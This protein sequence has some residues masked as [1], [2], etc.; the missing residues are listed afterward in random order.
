M[1]VRIWWLLIS[2][3]LLLLCTIAGCSA[4]PRIQAGAERVEITPPVP[5]PYNLGVEEIAHEIA[6]PL[7]ARI[8]YLEDDDDRVL[9]IAIDW[10][11]LLRTAHD[12]IR[13]AVA[14]STGLPMERIVV[15]ASHTHNAMWNNLDTEALLAEWGYHLVDREY[16]QGQLT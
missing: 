8:V 4:P 1:L 11:G 12:G 5:T 13:S 6:D 2:G 10:E 14:S 9:L 16:F 7:Y 3:V 15:N